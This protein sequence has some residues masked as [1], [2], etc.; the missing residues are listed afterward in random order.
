MA[1]QDLAGVGV[2]LAKGDCLEFPGS[3]QAKR[4]H[5][6]AAEKVQHPKHRKHS[7]RVFWSCWLVLKQVAS[8]TLSA[9]AFLDASSAH[10][11][12]IAV[13][14]LLT[15]VHEIVVGIVFRLMI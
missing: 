14:A 11:C 8:G 12:V 2:D 7:A 9:G 1:L 4:E 13:V 15:A 3:F 10:R 5:A 6:R